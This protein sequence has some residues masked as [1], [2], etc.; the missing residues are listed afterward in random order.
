[1][2]IN[3]TDEQEARQTQTGDNPVCHISNLHVVDNQTR[4]RI[5]TDAWKFFWLEHKKKGE[6]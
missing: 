3:S 1:M 2:Q 4:V 6:N 5:F